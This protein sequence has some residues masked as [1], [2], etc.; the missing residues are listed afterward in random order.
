MHLWFRF[1][2]LLACLH[3]QG[4]ALATAPF[5]DSMAQRTLACTACHG[6][7]GKAG[8]DGYYPRLAGKPA[9]YLFNQLQNFRAGRRHY[10]LMTGLLDNLDDA[11][12]QAIADHFATQTIPYPPPKAVNASAATLEH[13]RGLV[14]QGRP[15]QGL[16]ACVQCHGLELMGVNPN[17][18]GLLG[19]P[20]DYLNA[21]LGG[22][23]TGQRRARAPDCMA[24]IARL[25]SATDISAIAQWLTSQA[26][27]PQAHATPGK[28]AL[29]KAA[30]D[31]PCGSA[32]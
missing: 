30:T 15:E 4:N 2:L 13:G 31:L 20:G 21:Q 28:P 1:V 24:K 29:S 18:P 12:L 16:P 8:P 14:Q 23:Q 6:A 27:A 26:V 11:Y 25:L 32:P 9:G 22:W 7:Q 17:I 19:L 5:E 10:P 3:A